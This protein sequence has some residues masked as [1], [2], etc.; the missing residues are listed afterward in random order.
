M[1]NTKKQNT[2]PRYD[3]ISYSGKHQVEPS[4]DL[5]E[6]GVVT[7]GVLISTPF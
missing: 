1:K 3:V 5:Y 6:G 4:L 7:V 2:K